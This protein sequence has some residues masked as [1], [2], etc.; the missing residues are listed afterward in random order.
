MA[1]PRQLPI[2]RLISLLREMEPEELLM[3]QGAIRA[4]ALRAKDAAAEQA[5]LDL[6]ERSEADNG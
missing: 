4:L 2:D 1:R 5:G 6:A 3:A